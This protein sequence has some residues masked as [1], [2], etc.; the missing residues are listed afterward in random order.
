MFNTNL[1]TQQMNIIE[2]WLMDTVHCLSRRHRAIIDDGFDDASSE[3]ALQMLMLIFGCCK[4]S[5]KA[6][7][8]QLGKGFGRG[9]FSIADCL[10][11]QYARP[12]KHLCLRRRL[13]ENCDAKLSCRQTK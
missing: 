12:I 10:C 7:A 2:T 1:S 9:C 13:R 5:T 6:C 4:L 11:L 3:P 8:D